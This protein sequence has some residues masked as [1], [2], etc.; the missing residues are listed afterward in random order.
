VPLVLSA[1][2]NNWSVNIALFAA[3]YFLG[4]ICWIFVHSD[5]R[6]PQSPA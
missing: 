3:A 4:A 6:L 1:T 2:N 5:H